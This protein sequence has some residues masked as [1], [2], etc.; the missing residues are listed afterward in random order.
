MSEKKPRVLIADDEDAIRTLV[1]RMLRRAG[2]DPVEV[3]DGQHAIDTLDAGRF[4]AVVLDLMMPR[5]DG[6]GVVE[7]LIENQPRMMEKTVVMTAFPKTAAKERLHHLCAIISK[8]FDIEELIAVVARLREPLKSAQ[9]PTKVRI[10]S[11][12][13]SMSNGFCNTSVS[14]GKRSAK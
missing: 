13:R 9:P 1:S 5:V 6:F 3:S 11:S 2:F 12:I 4:D 7:H 10:T 8:P 14:S